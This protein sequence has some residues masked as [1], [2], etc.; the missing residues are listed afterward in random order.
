MVRRQRRRRR[1]HHEDVVFERTVVSVVRL[2]YVRPQTKMRGIKYRYALSLRVDLARITLCFTMESRGDTM[3]E[4]HS[5]RHCNCN[6]QKGNLSHRSVDT[7]TS[8]ENTKTSNTLSRF[9]SGMGSRLLTTDSGRMT[10]PLPGRAEPP[11]DDSHLPISIYGFWLLAKKGYQ[12]S[13][14]S[15]RLGSLLSS[16]PLVIAEFKLREEHPRRCHLPVAN[17]A[18]LYIWGSFENE[19][20][21]TCSLSKTQVPRFS[22]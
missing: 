21:C 12:S 7:I 14:F 6:R 13:K 4:G 22:K 19:V 11:G 10:S 17:S 3:S 9:G 8:D 20:S 16:V 1:R 18:Y 15:Y 2:I 5:V